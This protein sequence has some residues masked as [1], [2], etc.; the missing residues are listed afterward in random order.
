M[1]GPRIRVGFVVR[2]STYARASLAHNETVA[3]NPTCPALLTRNV[4]LCRPSSFSYGGRPRS[5]SSMC[6]AVRF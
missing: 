3:K 2:G 4:G 5:R 6:S 1:G